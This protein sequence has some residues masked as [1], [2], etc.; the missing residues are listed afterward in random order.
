[1]RNLGIERA[2]GKNEDL[3]LGRLERKKRNI[4][5]EV[6]NERR[7]SRQKVRR[8]RTGEGAR[9]ETEVLSDAGEVVRE[10]LSQWT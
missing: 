9:I 6:E 10:T 2:N 4:V 5:Q 8:R 3:L 1:L 7:K